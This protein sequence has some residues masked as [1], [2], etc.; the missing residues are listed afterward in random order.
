MFE[1]ALPYLALLF[2]VAWITVGVVY[3]DCPLCVLGRCLI[4]KPR[5]DP[6]APPAPTDA[7]SAPPG[8]G[9]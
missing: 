4:R 5:P 6:A 3:K 2:V 9:G 1:S 8:H 7:G